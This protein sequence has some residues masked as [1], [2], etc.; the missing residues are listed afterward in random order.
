THGKV[1]PAVRKILQ[2]Q[3]TFANH[4]SDAEALAALAPPPSSTTVAA[5]A[6]AAPTPPPATPAP[7]APTAA[8]SK[9]GNKRR[10]LAAGAASTPP[11]A[12]KGETPQPDTAMPDADTEAGGLLLATAPRFTPHPGD[13]DP[14]LRSRIPSMP[15]KE[16]VEKLLAER[17]RGYGEARAG[18]ESAPG[19]GTGRVKGRK[20]CEEAQSD[21]PS[22][23]QSTPHPSVPPASSPTSPPVPVHGPGEEAA[24]AQPDQE[25]FGDETGAVEDLRAGGHVLWSYQPR[26]GEEDQFADQMGEVRR[27]PRCDAASQRVTQETEA[28]GDAPGEG[29]GGEHEEELGGVEA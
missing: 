18:F 24:L 12:A 13:N 14:L 9:R 17:P 28:L 1:T 15:T 6:A 23:Q 3:K 16:E 5:A 27:E 8:Q 2:S 20:F 21:P 4:L 7:A 11:P 29:G 10:S 22:Q 26:W 25:G 19:G